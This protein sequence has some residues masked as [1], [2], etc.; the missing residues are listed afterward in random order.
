M[1]FARL[2]RKTL[3]LILTTVF[4]AAICPAQDVAPPVVTVFQIVTLSILGIACMNGFAASPLTLDDFTSGTYM[5]TVQNAQAQEPNYAVS[6]PGSLLGPARYTVFGLGAN[7]CVREQEIYRFLRCPSCKVGFNEHASWQLSRASR[8]ISFDESSPNYDLLKPLCRHVEIWHTV[9]NHI[10][11]GPNAIVEWFKG[12]ALRP[13]LSA[14]DVPA[15]GDY[16]EAYTNEIAA[17]Y[18][19]RF[20]GQI[21]LRFPRLFI[22][23]TR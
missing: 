10:V 14:L 12:S 11:A 15:G 2:A 16:L 6:A 20:D 1:K 3:L 7:P 4:L 21:L 9:Y 18:R 22:V 23:A 13:F 5:L 17:H 19:A 8:S